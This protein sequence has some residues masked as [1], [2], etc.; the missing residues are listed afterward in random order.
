MNRR[1]LLKRGPMALLGIGGAALGIKA[2]P[3]PICVTV[4]VN[5]SRFAKAV[6]TCVV[7]DYKANGSIRE[8]AQSDGVSHAELYDRA[9]SETE[10]QESCD[11]RLR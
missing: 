10:I 8:I 4:N 3:D 7:D 2:A 11:A 1:D 5:D 9:L 6:V